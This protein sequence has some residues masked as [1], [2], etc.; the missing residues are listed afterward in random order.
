[1]KLLADMHVAPA[2]RR[3][4]VRLGLALIVA[5]A[6]GYLPGGVMRRDPRAQ[7]LESQLDELRGQARDLAADNTALAREVEA[8]R[9]D[10]GA[11]E[12]RARG[13]LGMV[14]PDEIVVRVREA[15]AP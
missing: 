2:A 11:I 15:G 1:M 14:Y 6:I 12:D 13:D 7:K 8:L 3:W 5:I 4:A 9:S 10:V